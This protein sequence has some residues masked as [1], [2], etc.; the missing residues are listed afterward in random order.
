MI[1]IVFSNLDVLNGFEDIRLKTVK[2]GYTQGELQEDFD[3]FDD[4]FNAPNHSYWK[5]SVITVEE[6]ETECEALV[7]DI[8]NNEQYCIE[9][10]YEAISL[11]IAEICQAETE[12]MFGMEFPINGLQAVVISAI[13]EPEGYECIED[14]VENIGGS[15]E[16]AYDTVEIPEEN[17]NALFCICEE[18]EEEISIDG[19][20]IKV[21]GE[22]ISL[23]ETHKYEKRIAYLTEDI[24]NY[25]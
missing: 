14:V 22:E 9:N 4:A 12:D 17:V 25:Q 7:I 13:D 6:G 21:N 2:V 1:L 19:E 11:K 20:I 18:I 24:M 10:D 3:D 8:K 16:I 15:I 5:F 23:E